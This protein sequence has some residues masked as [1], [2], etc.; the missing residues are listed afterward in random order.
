MIYQCFICAYFKE[1]ISLRRD[2][3]AMI[4]CDRKNVILNLP[5]HFRA[6]TLHESGGKRDHR[7]GRCGP[8]LRLIARTKSQRDDIPTLRGSGV[9]LRS[10]CP[11]G[12]DSFD[13]RPEK[14]SKVEDA[15]K[16]R[17]FYSS[18]F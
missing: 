9:D 12:S 15:K 3:V 4:T 14:K 6:R 18:T 13:T 7:D 11:R 2:D 5:S 17:A 10:R 1:K 16:T 8:Q